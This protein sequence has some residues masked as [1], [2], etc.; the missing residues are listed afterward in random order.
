M[1]PEEVLG[2]LRRF[3]L[4]LSVLLFAGAL[5]EL[6]LVGHTED[7]IQWLA[8]AV[9]AVGGLAALAR[10]FGSGR[11]ILRLLRVSMVV[12]ILGSVFGVVMHLIGNVEFEQEINANAPTA[13]MLWRALKGGNPL[14]APGV[15]MVAAILSLA[16]T[17]RHEIPIQE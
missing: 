12:V 8:F 4:V 2:Q 1:R 14:L 5:V 13:T 16:A 3:L 7:T 11:G 17:Y 10:L 15:L 6:W 9:A